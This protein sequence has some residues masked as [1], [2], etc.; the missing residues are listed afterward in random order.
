METV[1]LETS[2]ISYLVGNP[3]QD[4]LNAQRQDLSRRWWHFRRSEFN[5]VVST[6]VWQEI[7]EG[8]QNEAEKRKSAI[9]P[10]QILHA[11][12]AILQ[13]ADAIVARGLLP[14][15]AQA[16]AI[17]I[18]IGA[19]YSVDYIVSWNFK[20]LVNASI[21]SRIRLLIES[22]GLRMPIVCTPEAL[23]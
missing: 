3:S 10:Y 1:Y 22:M 18:A 17:H 23:M 11:T 6:M 8:D 21:Q 2:F 12:P 20:H 19:V 5:C 15:K 16:D 14:T 9:A 4:E 7:A 13:L